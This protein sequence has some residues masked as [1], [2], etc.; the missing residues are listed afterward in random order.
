METLAALIQDHPEE[1]MQAWRERVSN[2]PS[3]R[4]KSRATIEDHI[5]NLLDELCNALVAETLESNIGVQINAWAVSHG[6]Q[7]STDHFDIADLVTEYNYLRETVAQFAMHHGVQLTP[8]LVDVIAGV[9]NAAIV[10]AIRAYTRNEQVAA[11]T[12][13]RQEMANLTHDLKTPLTAVMTASRILQQRLPPEASMSCGTMVKIIDRNCDRLHELMS[14]LVSETMG[15][16]GEALSLSLNDTALRHLVQKVVED[17]R[18]IAEDK[19]VP[20][21]NEVP[22]DF[23]VFGDEFLLEQVLHNLVSNALTYTEK[24]KVEIG[25]EELPTKETVFWVEDTGTGISSDRVQ[26]IFERGNGDPGRPGSSGLGLSIVDR[27][28][29]AHGGKVKVESEP[30]R[31]SKF[32]VF[33][34]AR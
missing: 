26:S 23:L 22:E 33:L 13:L 14:R 1:I 6:I 15:R 34:P 12:R 7:R 17:I 19:Q 20:V 11:D 24:G 30:G 27:I 5:P 9:L 31:G 18:S 28:I 4:G 3:A 29:K 8:K 25:A 2:L 16:P 32:S 21:R 10:A